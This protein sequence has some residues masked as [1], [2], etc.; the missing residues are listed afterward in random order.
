MVGVG[1]SVASPFWLTAWALGLAL[2][3]LV[4]NHFLPWPSFHMDAWAGFMAALG[5]FSLWVR[6][7]SPSR[8][9]ASACVVAALALLPGLQFALG[10]ISFAGQAWMPAIYLL[11]LAC[12]I[13]MGYRWESATPDQ[14]P[15][16]LFFAIAVAGV[17]SVWLQLST[18]LDLWRGGFMEV[19]WSMSFSGERP[20][21]NLGQPNLLATLLIWGLLAC[22]WFHV[23]GKLGASTAILVA[24]WLLIGV[25]L[26]Q[27]RMATLALATGLVVIFLWRRLWRS[28]RLPWVCF[29]LFVFLL[30]CPPILGWLQVLLD[31]GPER[32]F[33]RFSAVSGVQDARFAAWQTFAFAVVQRPWIGYGWTE[34]VHAQ[35]AVSG[36]LPALHAAFGHTHN[37]VLDLLA[38]NGLPVGLTI[39]VAILCWVWQSARSVRCA[40]DAVLLMLLGGIGIHAMLELPLQYA[41]FLL[42]V[43]MV[44]G[45]LD[46]RRGARALAHGPWWVWVV[47]LLAAVTLL[48]MVVRDYLRVEQAYTTLRFEEKRIGSAYLN[49]GT[50]PD[51]VLLTQ[52]QEW[53]RFARFQM[54]PGMHDADMVSFM[55]VANAFPTTTAFFRVGTMLA[56]NGRPVEAAQWLGKICPLIDASD[57][58][59]IEAAWKARAQADARLQAVLWPAS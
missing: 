56:L 22:L 27:S 43:G 52:M 46:A 37:L 47:P 49:P 35:L 34:L 51:V 24:V 8:V 39:V 18:W 53:F 54:Q 5:A 36:Q 4:P 19:W 1:F 14:L 50:P 10:L 38:W 26:T 48:G 12:A 3:W 58:P 17:V 45:V 20:Y 40:Q 41:H 21:A 29:G 9:P 59:S 25:A 13:G 42:P 32:D 23:N 30:L 15:N 7:R 28:A 44:V 31:V 33:Q 57:C 55:K 16:A 2:T 11:G 6:D